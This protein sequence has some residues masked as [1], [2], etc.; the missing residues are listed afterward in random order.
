[1][2][3]II[4]NALGI[5]SNGGRTLLLDLVES[6]PQINAKFT[7]FIDSRLLLPDC[8]N[9]NPHVKFI[10]LSSM[11]ISRYFVDLKIKKI[12]KK[13]D[14]VL[15]LNNLPPLFSLPCKTIVFL[16]NKYYVSRSSLKGFRFKSK[17]RII[18]EKAM[19]RFF[20]SRAN[21]IIVQTPS[22]AKD[23]LGL[24]AK[25]AGKVQVFPFCSSYQVSDLLVEDE[26]N[27]LSDK[28]FIYIASSEPHKN[29]WTLV[30]A[31]A[32]LKEE[33]FSPKLSLTIAANDSPS[34]NGLCK[35][36]E[37][38]GL[39]ILLLGAMS[40][41]DVEDLYKVCDAL[42]YPSR[43]ESFGIP[44]LEAKF[45]GVPIIASELDYVRDV[46]EPEETFDPNSELSLARAIKR[47]CGIEHR[48]LAIKAPVK[49]LEYCAQV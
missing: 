37:E 1:M 44:L 29:H 35:Y 49:F 14:R 46:V 21:R 33:G 32:L 45:H 40:R 10:R 22:M 9:S 31:F 34:T 13:G 47:F 28:H 43:L 7:F 16:Q 18:L 38:N 41:V 27:D 15:Y 23:V 30:K 11:L 5:V 2:D 39:N 42:I 26:R 19:I 3:H 36:I 20:I 48:N 8:F 25:V 4:V 12:A 24:T 17:V 6:S